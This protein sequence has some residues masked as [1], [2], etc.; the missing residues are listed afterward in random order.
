MRHPVATSV[1]FSPYNMNQ[2]KDICL[3]LPCILQERLDLVQYTVHYT[4]HCALYTVVYTVH[5]SVH[6]TLCT[7]LFH[8]K[9]GIKDDQVKFWV[10][11]HHYVLH[12]H[13]DENEVVNDL[14]C[15]ESFP[16]SDISF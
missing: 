10:R 8:M 4:V 5:C 7:L 2:L 6:C 16:H 9:A 3:S 14:T 15:Q 11:K 13:D 12:L 1:T